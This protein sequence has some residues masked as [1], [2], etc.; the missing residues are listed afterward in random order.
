MATYF[1]PSEKRSNP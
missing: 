1:E